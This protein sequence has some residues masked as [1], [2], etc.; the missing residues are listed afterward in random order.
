MVPLGDQ[1][2]QYQP[3]RSIPNFHESNRMVKMILDDLV[4]HFTDHSR[5]VVIVINF[6]GRIGKK[7]SFN[8][9]IW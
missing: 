3:N 5:D 2:S 8:L 6:W 9:Y 1:L 7:L 4:D